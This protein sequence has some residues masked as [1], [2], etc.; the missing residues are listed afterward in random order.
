MYCPAAGQND[1]HA[2][3]LLKEVYGAPGIVVLP[4]GHFIHEDAV[5]LIAYDPGKHGKHKS[6]LSGKYDPG[7]QPTQ[8]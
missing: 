4:S 3:L 7:L 5:F 8:A 2:L 1:K 6:L